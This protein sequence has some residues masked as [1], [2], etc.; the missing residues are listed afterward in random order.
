MLSP[1]LVSNLII[2]VQAIDNGG[3][4]DLIVVEL[5]VVLD[6]LLGVPV[7]YDEDVLSLVGRWLLRPKKILELTY[8]RKRKD[9]VASI[10]QLL[11]QPINP[12]L[13]N[14]AVEPK[15]AVFVLFGFACGA[16]R[17]RPRLL[18]RGRLV[19]N[20]LGGLRLEFN[21]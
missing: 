14:L 11:Y 19:L 16:H 9:V 15:E 12:A 13:I 17:Q 1:F 18:V 6:V 10:I 8:P 7:A 3:D 4:D 2:I 21:L 20:L 5:L